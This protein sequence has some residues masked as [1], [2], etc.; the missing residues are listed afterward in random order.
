MVDI[1]AETAGPPAQGESIS[2]AWSAVF[3]GAVCGA[4]LAFVLD[5]FGAAVGLAVSSAAPTWRD[6]SFALAFLSGIY[7]IL[8]AFL[9][10]GLGAYIAARIGE[11]LYNTAEERETRDG[12]L[13]LVVWGVMTLAAALILTIA[14]SGLSRLSAPSGGA[15]GPSASIAGEN[16]IAFDLD[17]LL[18]GGPRSTATP[19]AYIRAEAARILLT[20]SSHRGLSSEDRNYLVGLVERVTGLPPAEAQSRVNTA[21]DRARENIHR[22][23]NS[24]VILAFMIAAATLIGAVG[25]WFAAGLGGRQRDGMESGW[26]VVSWRRPQIRF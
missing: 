13:G 2:V 16:I 10:Y 21:T 5:A 24:G 25:A 18:R 7:L 9:S 19:N 20:T 23:R 4:G 17:K 6:A 1:G 3:A 8:T 12:V 11:R 26:P 14:A 15:S 22:A